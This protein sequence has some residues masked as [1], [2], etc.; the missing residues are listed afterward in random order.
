MV[1]L[2]QGVV[3]RASI[4]SKVLQATKSIESLRFTFYFLMSRLRGETIALY[5]D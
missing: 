4:I 1:F 3:Y 2:E 5:D